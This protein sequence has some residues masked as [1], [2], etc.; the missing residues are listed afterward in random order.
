[1]DVSGGR[2]QPQPGN[3][4][5]AEHH[6]K[7][8]PP[9][10]DPA[11]PA[12]PDAAEQFAQPGPAA[13]PAAP[14]AP[15][16]AATDSGL[17]GR[18]SG[19]D[20][21]EETENAGAAA[22][23]P[24]RASADAGSGGAPRPDDSAARPG[25]AAKTDGASGTR[26]TGADAAEPSDDAAAAA[27][28]PGGLSGGA[29]AGTAPPSDETAARNAAA[30]R[31][32]GVSDVWDAAPAP[33]TR[34]GNTPP[35]AV[36]RRADG[37]P[38]DGTDGSGAAGTG[39][40]ERGG[41]HGAG[42]DGPGGPRREA[43]RTDAAGPRA[44]PPREPQARP[45]AGDP[46]RTGTADGHAGTHGA[47]DARH[48]SHVTQQAAGHGP[49]DDGDPGRHGTHE[50]PH[51]GGHRNHDTPGTP[52]HDDTQ[53]PAPQHTPAGPAPGPSGSS[54]RTP[55]HSGNTGGKGSPPE[56]SRR[57]GLLMGRP[58]GVPVYV[59]PSWF[60]V[61][62]LI[63]WVFGGQVDRV[64]PELGAASYLV[65][66]FFAVAFY[67]SVLVHELA[68][69][70]AALRFKLPVRRIQLQFFG[71]VSE[72]EKEAE[73]PGREFVLA[74]VGPLLS[75]VLSGLFYLALL[76]VD[77]GTVP[78]VLLAGLMISNLIV[79]AFNLLPGLPLDGGRMLRAVVWKI[80]GKPMTGTVAAA[81]VGRA[82][83]VSVLIG[84]PLLTQ[85]GALGSAAEDSVGMDTVL[86]A[87]LAA[88]LAAI[89]WTG[90]GNSL[91]MARL[92]EHLPELR[93]RTLTRRAVP[94]ETDTPLSEALRRANAA[95]ARAL[96][97]VDAEG[98]PIAIVREAAIVGVPEH[99]RPWV[100]VG[101]LAQDLTDGM[102]VS[103]ELSGEEL[104]DALRATPATEYLVVEET[105]EIYGVLSAADVER[106]FVKAMARPS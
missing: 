4:K 91:R 19:P 55:A 43:G 31:K 57:G 75:L 29:D 17:A 8:I 87:L 7:P 102:R 82:L 98:S 93:A 68:H 16:G 64:L 33:V 76:A 35:D 24:G 53:G 5:S 80:S 28:R 3:D 10:P 63:T 12:P 71:G 81:W 88:I 74:F 37:A 69:T 54:G 61:A 67:A 59:A 14:N 52:R 51:A 50:T 92:R 106:A 6:H 86:D 90:A 36:A 99:R 89:I 101:T 32:D 13:G 45:G 49:Q 22:H 48:D 21:A 65:S 77:P 60:L 84:L 40:D 2:G 38:G 20:S 79:A 56:S 23:R 27:H 96:V 78:G 73:T 97:V 104:L 1:M 42:S 72:I 100:P 41:R 62:V 70:L 26:S 9:A 83:A 39:D 25:T 66:L 18:D 34:P 95:G 103:A 105:G 47:P 58:F 44:V 30:P 85:S 15:H 11:T 94:V 46:G